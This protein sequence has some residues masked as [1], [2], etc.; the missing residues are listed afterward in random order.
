[1]VKLNGNKVMTSIEFG[2]CAYKIGEIDLRKIIVN[3]LLQKLL[4]IPSRVV[5]FIDKNINMKILFAC[6][7]SLLN[8][9]T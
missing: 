1:M 9:S 3:L 5:A 8:S 4:V 2:V 7:I 6:L